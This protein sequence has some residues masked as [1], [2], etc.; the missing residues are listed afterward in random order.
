MKKNTK[1]PHW[2][3]AASIERNIKQQGY[4]KRGRFTVKPAPAPKSNNV[5]Q[6]KNAPPGIYFVTAPVK[7][8][9]FK[10]ETI[11]GFVPYPK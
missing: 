7:K 8:G 6:W 3:K 4:A 11:T 10:V 5:M 9:R 1:Q 2:K